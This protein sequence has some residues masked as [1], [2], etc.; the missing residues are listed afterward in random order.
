[1]GTENSVTTAQDLTCVTRVEEREQLW[2][3][4]MGVGGVYVEGPEGPVRHWLVKWVPQ[5]LH[6]LS[7]NTRFVLRLCG[8][9]GVV[10]EGAWPLAL[11]TFL[12]PLGGWRMP[13]GLL[14]SRPGGG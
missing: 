4:I 11:G 8:D 1:M 12:M 10:D 3:T 13:P 14:T 7:E 5:L 2:G 6:A 9:V